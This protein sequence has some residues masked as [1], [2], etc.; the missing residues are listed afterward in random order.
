[1]NRHLGETL[2]HEGHHAHLSCLVDDPMA[3]APSAGNWREQSEAAGAIHAVR[4][5]GTVTLTFSDESAS[6]VANVLEFL[7]FAWQD[8]AVH[9]IRL[10][11][12]T[13][14]QK[15]LTAAWSSE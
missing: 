13:Q 11:P 14:K 8:T 6:D 4:G 2:R 5:Q 1:M 7:Q 12:E 15:Q 10:V 9:R 3:C